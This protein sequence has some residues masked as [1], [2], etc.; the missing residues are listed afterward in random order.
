VLSEN[1][2]ANYSSG[3]VIVNSRSLRTG[4]CF[5]LLANTTL[6]VALQE[7]IVFWAFP[8]NERDICMY[9]SMSRLP[10]SSDEFVGSPFYRGI[11]L[12]E[13]G[14]VRDVLQV[15]ECLALRSQMAG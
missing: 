4:S 14:C 9:S 10:A 8:R 12:L 7:R 3:V 13:C 11:K 2:P 5:T 6:N 1:A 15:G